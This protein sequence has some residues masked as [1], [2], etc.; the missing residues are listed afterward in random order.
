MSSIQGVT[1]NSDSIVLD[2]F[3]L[4]QKYKQLYGENTVVLLQVGS[5]YECYALKNPNNGSYEITQIK[6][7][8]EIC[9][10]NIAD[11]KNTLGDSKETITDFPDF[12]SHV[13]SKS[14]KAWLKSIPPCQVVMAGL[15]DYMIDKYIGKLSENGFT[16]V[17]YS[18]HKDGKEVTRKLDRIYSPSTYISDDI[19]SSNQLSNNCMC[20]WF[21]T[22]KSNNNQRYDPKGCFAENVDSHIVCGVSS[23]NIFTG[24]ST[25]FEYTTPNFINPTT[26]DELERCISTI[27]PCEII[28]I[29]D[30]EDDNTIKKII[31]YIG[32]SSH[33]TFHNIQISKCLNQDTKTKID[34]CTKQVYI[35]EILSI[36]FSQDAF[37][38]CTE[39]QNSIMGT[40]SFC[41]LLNFI[42]EHNPDLVRKIN[43]PVF[44]NTN[45]RMVLAN[46]TLRQLNI[47]D[48]NS[49]DCRSA[50]HLSSV[51]SF[52]NKCCTP[53]GKRKL[54]YQITN[55]TFNQEWLNQEYTNID[56]ILQ[57]FPDNIG[58]IRKKLQQVR[59]I[60]KMLR[61]I[62]THKLLPS[63]IYHLYNSCKI[64]QELYIDYPTIFDDT[65]NDSF[66][67][68]LKSFL[69]FLEHHFVL[70]LC[71]NTYSLTTFEENIICI[72]VSTEL[73][74]NINRQ[75]VLNYTIIQLQTALTQLLTNEN[76]KY[77]DC[78][79]IHETEKS[80]KSFQITKTRGKLLRKILDDLIKND[81]I[82]MVYNNE[83]MVYAKDV[84]ITTASGSNDEIEFPY[85]KQITKELFKLQEEFNS[86]ITKT[87]QEIL[88][89]I[90]VSWFEKIESFSNYIS[91]I[92]VLVNKSYIAKTYN[93]CRPRI[94]ESESSFFKAEGI[95]HALIEHIN[96]N[97]LYVS[98]D[99]EL[100]S[101]GILLYGI[102]SSGKT[103]LIRSI[104]ICVILSQSGCFVPCSSFIFSPYHSIFSRIIG[105]DNLFKNLSTFVVEMTE[106]RTILNYCDENSLILGDELCSGTEI[107]SALSIIISSLMRLH[108]KK[109]SFIF[110][111]HFHEIVNYYT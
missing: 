20:V 50:G 77:T 6:R 90:E 71:A 97:E 84:K 92:D 56:K 5:F 54:Q 48:D 14:I 42:Q 70:E 94:Q 85:L 78:I 69:G 25:L 65:K 32:I 104:G 53:M 38:I 100:G 74:D 80:G 88:K 61:Q 87:Y 7:F 60:E 3:E 44:T 31:Q 89:K 36:F 11:K 28:I 18:Q 111:T 27:N 63:S 24:E 47:I 15:R 51:L 23:I 19:N 98:N 105:N 96:T 93:F 68:S 86:L 75:K 52:I 45:D 108:E 99:V 12:P 83:Y 59:D 22:Y 110:A 102:N 17:I 55:P 58:T 72:G 76:S 66:A 64:I 37:N 43:L 73:D 41:Y 49:T 109:S 39:F 91:K 26:F 107:Q 62:L 2:Y 57:F 8:T 95:R 46:H 82:S 13:S 29:S 21:D 101:S 1:T 81:E 9:N 4:T 34:N 33:T 30:F 103:S 16:S 40:Q 67:D 35:Q 10:F 106:L 79:K